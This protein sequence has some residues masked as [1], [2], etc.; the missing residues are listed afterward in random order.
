MKYTGDRLVTYESSKQLLRQRSITRATYNDIIHDL[1]KRQKT[2]ERSAVAAAARAETRA[3]AAE[4]EA[5]RKRIVR[6]AQLAIRAKAKR[7]A[8]ILAKTTFWKSQIPGG[9]L[10]ILL[11]YTKYPNMLLELDSSSCMS[12]ESWLRAENFDLQNNPIIYATPC[13]ATF[14]YGSMTGRLSLL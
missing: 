4:K 3:I 5:E 8:A 12:T 1:N 11:Q 9:L 10:K 14:I 6:K 7:I 13:S 2:A